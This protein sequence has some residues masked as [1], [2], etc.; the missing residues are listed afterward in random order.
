MS[1]ETTETQAPRTFWHSDYRK[2]CDLIKSFRH[3]HCDTSTAKPAASQEWADQLAQNAA[4]VFQAE[5]EASGTV[6]STERFL[7]DTQLPQATGNVMLDSPPALED[8][9]F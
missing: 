1:T 6:F 4:L 5:A 8:E 9:V 7:K 3:V 2:T